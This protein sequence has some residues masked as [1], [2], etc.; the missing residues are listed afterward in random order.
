MLVNNEHAISANNVSFAYNGHDVLKDISLDVKQGEYVGVIGPNGGG[1]TTFLKIVLGL[2]KPNKGSLSLFGKPP[3]EARKFGRI[4]YVPQRATQFENRFPAT[5]LEVVQSGLS[6]IPTAKRQPNAVQNA[7]E[8][9]DI[10]SI[11]SQ[12]L[13]E[14]SGGQRQRVFIARCLTAQPKMLLLDEPVTGVD[15]PSKDRFYSLLKTLN[16]QGITI[17]FVTHDVDTIAKEVSQV[18]CLNQKVCCHAS[19]QDFLKK[20]VLDELYSSNQRTHV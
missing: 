12:P 17:L 13:Y 1:K 11:Q 14:L 5:V 9:T 2:L 6:G 7:M 16:K 15:T 18:L 3:H 8:V 10:T 4:G 19:P 20:H